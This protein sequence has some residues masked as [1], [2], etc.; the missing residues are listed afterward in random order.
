MEKLFIETIKNEFRQMC[1][2]LSVSEIFQ[3][4]DLI[5]AIERMEKLLIKLSY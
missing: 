2:S 1:G 5:E 4:Q 3:N